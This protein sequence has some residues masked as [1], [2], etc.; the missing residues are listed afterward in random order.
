MFLKREGA[1]P[2]GK[3]HTLNNHLV[4]KE[5]PLAISDEGEGRVAPREAAHPT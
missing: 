5:R 3:H 4:L 2:A 1:T